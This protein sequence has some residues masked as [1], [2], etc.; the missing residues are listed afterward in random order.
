M[1]KYSTTEIWPWICHLVAHTSSSSLPD[2]S[3]EAY[4]AAPPVPHDV[5]QQAGGQLAYWEQA[6][7]TRPRLAQFA[8]K[9][10]TAPGM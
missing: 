2:D 5:I 8:L 7:K 9:N 6:L 10:L 1:D 4:W 3:L